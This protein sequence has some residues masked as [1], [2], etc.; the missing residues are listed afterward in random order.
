MNVKNDSIMFLVELKIKRRKFPV[1]DGRNDGVISSRQQRGKP[2]FRS[3]SVFTLDFNRVRPR[4]VNIDQAAEF[5]QLMRRSENLC[6]ILVCKQKP[7]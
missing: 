2:F 3:E 5:L 1:R 4:I 6:A 7:G